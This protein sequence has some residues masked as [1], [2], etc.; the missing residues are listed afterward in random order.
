MSNFYSKNPFIADAV[1]Q[2]IKTYP[3]SILTAASFPVRTQKQKQKRLKTVKS[4]FL[5]K[6]TK[7]N[8]HTAKP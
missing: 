6:E 3:V 5:I 1:N 7:Q 2:K 4:I 8:K